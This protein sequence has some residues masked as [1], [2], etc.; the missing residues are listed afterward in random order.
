MTETSAPIG[1]NARALA[2]T[3]RWSPNVTGLLARFAQIA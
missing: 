2:P 3:G 1:S